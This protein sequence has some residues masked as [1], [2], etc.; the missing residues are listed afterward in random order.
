MTG[1]YLKAVTPS[2]IKR[3]DF[4]SIENEFLNNLMLEHSLDINEAIAVCV[5]FSANPQSNMHSLASII[6][7]ESRVKK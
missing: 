7:V 4:S 6:K 5:M 1:I 2:I 3:L